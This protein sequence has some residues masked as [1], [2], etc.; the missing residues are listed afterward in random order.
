MERGRKKKRRREK[1]KDRA[2]ANGKEEDINE[3]I[4]GRE[5]VGVK[6]RKEEGKESRIRIGKG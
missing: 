6:G 2:R 4:E 3:T 5:W 1:E